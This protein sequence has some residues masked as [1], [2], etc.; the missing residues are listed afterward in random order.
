MENHRDND[1]KN[2]NYDISLSSKDLYKVFAADYLIH[3]Y[4]S[5]NKREIEKSLVKLIEGLEIFVLPLDYL[6]LEPIS[7]T[8]LF[9]KKALSYNLIGKSKDDKCFNSIFISKLHKVFGNFLK[10]LVKDFIHTNNDLKFIKQK[11]RNDCKPV[12]SS[13]AIL[14]NV[15][16]MFF[17]YDKRIDIE[18]RPE[19]SPMAPKVIIEYKKMHIYKVKCAVKKSCS[20]FYLESNEGLLRTWKKDNLH[21]VNRVNS[22]EEILLFSFIP[23]ESCK[24]LDNLH[25]NLIENLDKPL[26]EIIKVVPEKKQVKNTLNQILEKK[27][28][29][30]NAKWWVPVYNLLMRTSSKDKES[31]PVIEKEWKELYYLSMLLI[32]AYGGIDTESLNFIASKVFEDSKGCTEELEISL[33]NY[34]SFYDKVLAYEILPI[35]F[36]TQISPMT[37]EKVESI[38]M[39][40][41]DYIKKV[42]TPK[43]IELQEVIS[44]KEVEKGYPAIYS[45]HSLFKDKQKE[46]A[47]WKDYLLKTYII[48]ELIDSAAV[49]N[50][51]E[52][53]EHDKSCKETYIIYTEPV[54]KTLK[55]TETFYFCNG[56]KELW[57]NDI[58]NQIVVLV[59]ECECFLGDINL[60]RIYITKREVKIAFIDHNYRS[61]SLKKSRVQKFDEVAKQIVNIVRSF[62]LTEKYITNKLIGHNREE[63]YINIG[64]IHLFS[65]AIALFKLFFG[66][67]IESTDGKLFNIKLPGNNTI[68]N[69]EIVRNILIKAAAID[70]ENIHCDITYTD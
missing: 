37:D 63:C 43:L 13:L 21:R 69:S 53:K 39:T 28:I 55:D 61:Y 22:K 41:K 57:M 11:D 48:N 49:N 24:L 35:L 38:I 50:K 1:K 17:E 67:K 14:L 33:I 19:F 56:I 9:V 16:I 68:E 30:S 47:E 32:T 52:V 44:V 10:I 54:F 4:R 64:K 5:Y 34:I 65:F 31:K 6:T 7:N 62:N 20:K 15:D 51:E 58:Y 45:Y 66:V 25:N 26:K 29:K 23:D 27:N 12:L 42:T 70:I 60:D 18:P 40:I 59:N 3:F 46:K 8:F 36:K 2:F